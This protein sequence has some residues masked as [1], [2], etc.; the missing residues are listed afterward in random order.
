MKIIVK[1]LEYLIGWIRSKNDLLSNDLEELLET[2]RIFQSNIEQLKNHIDFLE[3]RIT[4]ATKE[5]NSLREEYNSLVTQIEF[6]KN[7]ANKKLK[8]ERERIVN[9][10]DEDILREDI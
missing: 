6:L 5:E 4:E 1:I 9:E 3:D 2:R 10:R 8:E 7:N